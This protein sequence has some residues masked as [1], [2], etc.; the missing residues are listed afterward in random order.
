M[1]TLV[2][3]IVLLLALTNSF[4][5]A[6][7]PEVRRDIL[8]IRLDMTK[9]EAQAR[10]KEIGSF[11]RADRKQQE[12]WAT[13]DKTFSHVIVGYE[14]EGPGLR[15]VTAVVR[16]DNDAERMRYSD[17]GKVEAARQA[18]D[19]AIKNFNF[20]W[21]LPSVPGHPKMLVIA[22]GRDP[23]FLSTYSLK[24]LDGGGAAEEEKKPDAAAP[25]KP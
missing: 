18:G 23:E 15:Y 9:E 3:L 1:R 6:A 17:I 24:R 5:P 2:S 25:P 20:E 22:R 16:D 4:M 14:K 13:K 11:V 21:T 8:G 12:V 10:L 7:E 19:P